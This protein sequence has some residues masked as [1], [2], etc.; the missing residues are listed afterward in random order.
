[1]KGAVNILEA[2]ERTL[3]ISRGQTTQDQKWSLEPV[4]CLGACSIAPV[5]KI[6][7]EVLGNLQS[8]DVEKVI[9]DFGKNTR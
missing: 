8:K 1:V 9:S 4:A 7:E 5:V 2:F 6:G 3:G